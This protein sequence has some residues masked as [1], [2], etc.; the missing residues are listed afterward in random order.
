M[1]KE[2]GLLFSF[3]SI[4]HLKKCLLKFF[5]KSSNYVFSSSGGEDIK[6]EEKEEKKLKCNNRSNE[7]TFKADDGGGSS[8][9]DEFEREMEEDLDEKV[10]RLEEGM[11]ATKNEDFYDPFEDKR[12]QAWEDQI[13]RSYLQRSHVKVPTDQKNNC[14]SNVRHKRKFVGFEDE[15]SKSTK[16]K[17]PMS[18]AVLNCPCCMQVLCLD[19]QRYHD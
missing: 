18:D 5:Y 1:N 19:C 4:K 9:E 10:E 8:S 6:D 12:D 16:E 2:T 3:N 15:R 14:S 13:R 17:L 11:G 7:Y